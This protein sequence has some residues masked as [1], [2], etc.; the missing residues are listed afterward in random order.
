VG[1]RIKATHLFLMS[2]AAT[3][4]Q[5]VFNPEQGCQDEVVVQRNGQH[6]LTS[7]YNAHP[8]SEAPP[9]GARTFLFI[10]C[11]VCKG[12]VGVCA[13]PYD[14]VQYGA[15][16]YVACAVGGFAGVPRRTLRLLRKAV[17]AFNDA[18][19]TEVSVQGS[20]N[21]ALNVQRAAT[22]A[23]Q[24]PRDFPRLPSTLR[25]GCAAAPERRAAQVLDSS[26]DESV[27][28][29]SASYRPRQVVGNKGTLHR[30][31][32]W[33]DG[34]SSSSDAGSDVES[35]APAEDAS[36]S[37][38]ELLAWQAVDAAGKRAHHT[39][40]SASCED[41]GGSWAEEY[42]PEAP[43]LHR[44]VNAVHAASSPSTH[45][46]WLQAWRSVQQLQALL[47]GAPMCH[48]AALLQT[49]NAS[50]KALHRAFPVHF[51]VTM[52]SAPDGA[53]VPEALRQFLQQGKVEEATRAVLHKWECRQ[54]T[55]EEAS[56]DL[57]CIL[58]AGV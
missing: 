29:V 52:G 45:R 42:R 38:W 47:P 39:A 1:V 53:P 3:S 41:T 12:A 37:S 4:V 40:A 20:C 36:V 43:G 58:C 22:S 16:L 44:G 15:K 54:V 8:L 35:V 14:A 13:L 2:A 33:D 55:P 50:C 30:R 26:E 5:V 56:R 10:M 21:G 11:N 28:H 9:K 27:V 18:G 23:A 48:L 24:R 19:M 51:A 46:A 57:R 34:A 6:V 31:R 17:R 7:A 25:G 32:Q 49:H